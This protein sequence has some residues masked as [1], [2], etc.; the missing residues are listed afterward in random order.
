MKPEEA[1]KELSYD[2]TAYGG[3]C[4]F[5]VRQEAVKALAKQIPMKP[6]GDLHSVPHYRCPACIS[7]VVLYEDSPK[8]PCCQWCGQKLDWGDT[9]GK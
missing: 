7:T 3:K 2:D 5:E 9:N 8:H 6:I 1:L 4:T